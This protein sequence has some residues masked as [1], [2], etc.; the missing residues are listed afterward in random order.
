M[1]LY[2]LTMIFDEPPYGWSESYFATADTPAAAVGLAAGLGPAR[3]A[4]C[5]GDV[6]LIGIRVS[7]DAIRGDAQL[8]N[9][10]TD[11]RIPLVG[12]CPATGPAESEVAYLIRLETQA[13]T[14]GPT[15]RANSRRL[16]QLRGLPEDIIEGNHVN[17]NPG[18]AGQTWFQNLTAFRAFLSA[19]PGVLFGP[20]QLRQQQPYI[21]PVSGPTPMDDL[22]V[23]TV[24]P[25][26]ITVTTALN[27]P[28]GLVLR[29]SVR[30]GDRL[31]I[32]G[33]ASSRGINGQWIVS[34]ISGTGPVVYR[35][36]PHRGYAA[37]RTTPL[38]PPG[39]T[40]AYLGYAGS[41]IVR[42]V[43]MARLTTRET[44]RPFGL[45]AGRRKTR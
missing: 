8:A 6:R 20:W 43:D 44:G 7:D 34:A 1:A 39:G 3:M 38:Q 10:S 16:L 28:T 23:D 24:N 18:V 41:N 14:P 40:I 25:Q 17:P 2:R 22:V 30:V 26:Y 5:P 27:I 35:L 45:P 13:P 29:P 4:L 32:R 42:A 21:D 12:S 33:L 15:A 19:L 37:Y 11:G 31:L 9:H 36:G